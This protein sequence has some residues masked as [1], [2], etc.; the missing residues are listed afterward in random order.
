MDR[1][2]P[3]WRLPAGCGSWGV[4][5]GLPGCWRAPPLNP[6]PRTSDPVLDGVGPIHG[7]RQSWANFFEEK[8]I[9]PGALWERHPRAVCWGSQGFAGSGRGLGWHLGRKRRGSFQATGGSRT[10]LQGVLCK[11]EAGAGN[12]V[13]EGT[14]VGWRRLWLP[15]MRAP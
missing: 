5:P 1:R 11:Y 4:F 15:L 3:A 2:N 10:V 7:T 12:R 9:I 8:K 6:F 14:R 13:Q